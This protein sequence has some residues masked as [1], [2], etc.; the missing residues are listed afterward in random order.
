MIFVE[1]IFFMNWIVNK[2]NW[3]KIN[4]IFLMI[5]KLLKISFK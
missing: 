4:Y 3:I 5:K 2:V 1:F